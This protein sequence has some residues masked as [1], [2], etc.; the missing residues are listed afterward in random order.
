MDQIS[1]SHFGSNYLQFLMPQTWTAALIVAG[2]RLLESVLT[3]QR[4]LFPVPCEAQIARPVADSLE[5]QICEARN[6]ALQQCTRDQAEERCEHCDTRYTLDLVS[7]IVGVVSSVISWLPCLL[8]RRRNG[9]NSE[10]TGARR[11][12][13]RP[14]VGQGILD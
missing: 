12:R 1:C 4:I 5:L 6:I 13:R 11:L 3:Q 10:S 8:C 2:V 9:R 14:A 7:V